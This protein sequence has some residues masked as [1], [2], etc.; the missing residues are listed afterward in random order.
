[1]DS[2]FQFFIAA[3]SVKKLNVNDVAFRRD[4]EPRH[5]RNDTAFHVDIGKSISKVSKPDRLHYRATKM[6]GKG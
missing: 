3:F 5:A 1:M 2:R 6:V 4:A